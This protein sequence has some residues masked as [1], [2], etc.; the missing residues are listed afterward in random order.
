[1][2]NNSHVYIN[3]INFT[4][5]ASN[6]TIRLNNGGHPAQGRVEILH[7]GIWGTICDYSWDILDAQVVC[8]QL[9]YDHAVAATLASSFGRGIDKIWLSQVGCGGHEL[10]VEECSHRSWGDKY[11]C[12]DDHAKDAGVVCAGIYSSHN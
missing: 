4:F 6:R 12:A 2:I 8:R 7:N 5:S 11:N 1:M 10:S 9:G 3:L